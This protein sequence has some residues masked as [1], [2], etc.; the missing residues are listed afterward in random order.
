MDTLNKILVR[1]DEK[2]KTQKDLC[3]YLGLNRNAV[4][5]WKAGKSKSY[6]KTVTLGKIA[7]YLDV[8]VNYLLGNEQREVT[9]DELKFALF[10]DA[11]VD[12]AV[13][14]DVLEYAKIRQKM[15]ESK[16]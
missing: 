10:D 9:K 14:E 3:D 13:L 11:E 7:D 1:L 2:G 5:S 4:T 16:R 15:A 8:S 6:L 12:D